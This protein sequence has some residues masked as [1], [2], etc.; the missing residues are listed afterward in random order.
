MIIDVER[1]GIVPG[2]KPKDAAFAAMMRIVKAGDVIQFE[3]GRYEFSNPI[4]IGDG[5]PAYGAD[6][7]AVSTL[8]GVT[9]AGRGAGAGPS[10]IG[11]A[12]ITEI[13]CPGIRLCGPIAECGIEN[14]TLTGGGIEMAHTFRCRVERVNVWNP[15]SFGLWLQGNPGP[16]PPGCAVNA[17]ANSIRDLRIQLSEENSIGIIV[18]RDKVEGEGTSQNRF[19]RCTVIGNGSLKTN[20]GLSLRFCDYNIF[21]MLQISYCRKAYVDIPFVAV[22]NV[23]IPVAGQIGGN[24]PSNIIMRDAVLQDPYPIHWDPRWSPLTS[25]LHL[26]RFVREWDGG[27]P[28]IDASY[29]PPFPKHPKI[30]GSDTTGRIYAKL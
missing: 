28:A 11:M 24:Y 17:S 14:L 30:F 21:E 7:G 10:E 29:G 25:G 23:G 4:V 5:R 6:K 16:L 13:A 18:G 9:I 12:P 2:T 26:E 22:P 20:I 8:H 3:A 19:E 15:R 27:N 1:Y